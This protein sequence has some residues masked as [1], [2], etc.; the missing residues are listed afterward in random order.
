MKHTNYEAHA[1]FHALLLF[2]SLRFICFHLLFALLVLPLEACN[3]VSTNKIIVLCEYTFIF[4]F[5][6]S[7]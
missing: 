1:I 7:T 6:D 5:F 2:P 4:T 3:K